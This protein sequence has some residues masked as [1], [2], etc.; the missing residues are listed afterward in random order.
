MNKKWKYLKLGDIRLSDMGNGFLVSLFANYVDRTIWDNT[1]LE[2]YTMLNLV[3]SHR[4]LSENLDVTLSVY[5]LLNDQHI[6]HPEG[7]EVGRSMTLRLMYR[8]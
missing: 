4:P 6:E 3:V 8:I 5:N 1:E 7:T 2:S